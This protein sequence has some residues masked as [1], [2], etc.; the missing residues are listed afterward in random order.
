VGRS[1]MSQIEGGASGAGSARPDASRGEVPPQDDSHDLQ[2]MRERVAAARADLARLP[3]AADRGAG[4]VDPATGESWHRGNVLGHVSEML[5]YWAGQI[6]GAVDGSS[7]IGRDEKGAALRRQGIDEGNGLSEIELR[8]VVDRKIGRVLVLLAAMN[9]EDLDRTVDF[10]NREGNRKARVGE[11]LQN[12][13]V[14][15]L[16]E[17]VQQLAGLESQA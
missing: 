7:T 13:I 14:G 17:H 12:L 2:A 8:K 3:V 11:L 5:D 16:E 10:H 1:Q 15:H 6:Q 9:P 4:P